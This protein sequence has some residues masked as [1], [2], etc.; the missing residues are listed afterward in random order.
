MA[1]DRLLEGK[2]AMITGAGRGIGRDYALAFAAAG[3]KVLVNDLGGTTQGEGEDRIPAMEVAKEI[4]DAG[5][6]AVVNFSSV[7]DFK[8]AQGMVDQCMDELGGLDIVVNNAGILRD[9]IFH[10]MTE[11][12]WDSVISVHLKGSF[13]TSRA[14][15]T[16]F[17]E[18]ESGAFIHMTS[19]S[20]LIGNFGQANY[21]AAKLGIAGLSKSIALDMGRF[22]VR[23]NCMSPFA[24]S[25][26]IGTIP[27]ADEAQRERIEKLKTMTTAKIAPVAVGLCAPEST[28]TG[29][30]FAVRN[31][32][33]FLMG[34]SRPIRSVHRGEG[35]TPETVLNHAMPSME[36]SFYGLDRSQD[37]FTWDPI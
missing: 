19:T 16:V 14:A 28:V 6:K 26:M 5:G 20:G 18:Q 37:V 24:W 34:Q 4:E 27:I 15:A 9:V 25:R 10:K 1:G 30:I 7:S 17:R 36:A 22:N 11:E 23:S 21:A 33:I 8:A 32:E 12:D 3:A 31:N 35:W 13:N 29:Q 2:V